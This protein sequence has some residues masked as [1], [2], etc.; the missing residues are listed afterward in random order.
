MTTSLPFLNAK[1]HL[2]GTALALQKRSKK[3][4]FVGEL[5]HQNGARAGF[6]FLGRLGRTMRDSI[7]RLLPSRR[8][9]RTGDW[10]AMLCNGFIPFLSS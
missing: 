7:V 9:G 6:P 1:R 2:R 10:K 5:Y 3:I 4:H 8:G